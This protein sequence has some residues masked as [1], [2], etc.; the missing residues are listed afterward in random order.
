MYC[1]RKSTGPGGGQTI[2]LRKNFRLMY[3]LY[4]RSQKEK[5][6]LTGGT[7]YLF[8]CF[9]PIIWFSNV[10]PSPALNICL[11]I[12]NKIILSFSWSVPLNYWPRII[13]F[14]LCLCLRLQ[15]WKW[16]SGTRKVASAFTTSKQINTGYCSP[17]RLL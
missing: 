5:K 12:E 3:K 16:L 4:T 17:V 7:F 9:S 13:L 6:E 11:R 8:I 10:S 2:K 1:R 15:T 14:F